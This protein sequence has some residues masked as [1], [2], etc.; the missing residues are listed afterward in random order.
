MA[1]HNDLK[2]LEI[3]RA[4][5]QQHERHHPPRHHIQERRQHQ[6]LPSSTEPAT[7]RAR[8]DPKRPRPTHDRVLAPHTIRL[9]RRIRTGARMSMSMSQKGWEDALLARSRRMPTGV[10]ACLLYT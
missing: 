4:K 3:R 2:L 8:S 9:Y 5:T 7:L 6:P 1:K 10:K